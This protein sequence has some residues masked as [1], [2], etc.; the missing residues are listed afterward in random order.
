MMMM[1]KVRASNINEMCGI[2]NASEEV[3]NAS[4]FFDCKPHGRRRGS[5][6]SMK[7]EVR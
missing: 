7:I 6:V 1:M 2:C 3:R 4:S 5:E